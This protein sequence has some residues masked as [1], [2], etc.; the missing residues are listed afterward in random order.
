MTTLAFTFSTNGLY[1]VSLTGTKLNPVFNSKD[2]I[3]LPANHSVAQTVTWFEN[4]LDI[5]LN[6]IHPDNVS[7]KLTINNVT[8]N[9]VQ[10][11]YYG[12][13]MLISLCQKKTIPIIH[14]SP[15]SIVGSKFGLPKNS[16]LHAFIDQKIGTHPPYWDTK[17]KDTALIA[18]ILLQ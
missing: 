8:N 9:M 2:K 7:Y 15:S 10:N 12:Q 1:Y 17:M 16:D 14:T 5:L 18:L 6:T 11:C 3:T 4:Q 13:A